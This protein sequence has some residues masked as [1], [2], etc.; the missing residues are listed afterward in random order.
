MPYVSCFENKKHLKITSVKVNYIDLRMNTYINDLESV[1][2]TFFQPV[3]LALQ[4]IYS[5]ALGCYFFLHL[6]CHFN[7]YNTI[8]TSFKMINDK[9]LLSKPNLQY[10]Y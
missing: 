7:S 2:Q 8:N 3:D 9:D 5:A 6:S 4:G 1:F 10:F